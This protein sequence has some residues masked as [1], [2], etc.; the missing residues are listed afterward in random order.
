MDEPLCTVGNR[1]GNIVEIHYSQLLR[2][3]AN[4]RPLTFGVRT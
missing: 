1:L 2:M 3:S 4:M